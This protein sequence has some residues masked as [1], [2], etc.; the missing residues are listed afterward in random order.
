MDARPPTP[1]EHAV[2]E[3]LQTSRL[4]LAPAIPQ[5]DVAVGY[6]GAMD[7]LGI[8]GDW[9]SV[10]DLPGATFLVVGDIARARSGRNR[11]D[12]RSEDHPAAPH[13]CW[14]P[15]PRARPSRRRVARQ[16]R[17]LRVCGDRTGRQDPNHPYP[18]QRRSSIPSL[19]SS[20][21]HRR[22]PQRH[23]ST[24][25]RHRLP[26]RCADQNTSSRRETPFCSTPTA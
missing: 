20:Q 17:S 9:Y 26:R 14:H 4:A 5:L 8:G 23:P 2:L 24:V 13:H 6:Q 10:I 21:R 1:Q 15:D 19:P 7:R 11:R 25:A 16:A 12:G 22:D 18:P 3:R